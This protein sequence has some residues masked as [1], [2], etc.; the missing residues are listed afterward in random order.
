M[1]SF[2][3][4]TPTCI[5]ILP[6]K[7]LQPEFVDVVNDA[8]SSLRIELGAVLDSL[9]L[10]GSVAR[11]NAQAG[12]SDLDLTLVL[13]R[14]LATQETHSLERVRTGLEDRHPEVSKVDFDIGVLEDVL[15]PDIFNRHGS[16]ISKLPI[17]A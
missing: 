11:A 9:Y 1:K 7:P 8:I 16:Q 17:D 14:S 13:S 2:N 12:K 15:N 4:F 10:Y 5:E 6:P 3:D